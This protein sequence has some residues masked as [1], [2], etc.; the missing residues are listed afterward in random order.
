MNTQD[1]HHIS[2]VGGTALDHKT[3]CSVFNIVQR[4]RVGVTDKN[5]MTKSFKL[6]SKYFNKTKAGKHLTIQ[7]LYVCA[8]DDVEQLLETD[9]QISVAR[10]S[11]QSTICLASATIQQW[12]HVLGEAHKDGF[13]LL[14]ETYS[15]FL[16]LGLRDLFTVRR[17]TGIK[18]NQ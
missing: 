18:R 17:K 13:I 9:L 5:S 2:V 12:N 3:L 1:A 15:R 11:D 6:L 10:Q 16:D 8:D 14:I 4:K 7:V